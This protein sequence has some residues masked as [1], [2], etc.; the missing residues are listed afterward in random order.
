MSEDDQSVRYKSK[1]T[2]AGSSTGV[3]F[4][5]SRTSHTHPEASFTPKF[6]PFSADKPARQSCA[7]DRYS[8][9][10]RDDIGR[11]STR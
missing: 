8:D 7:F 5:S 1:R 11:V 10:R 2:P 3:N 9:T 4:I 6:Q